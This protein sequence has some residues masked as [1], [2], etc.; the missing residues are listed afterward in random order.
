MLVSHK[1][2]FIFIANPKTATT[3]ISKFLRTHDESIVANRFENETKKIKFNEHAFPTV[4]KQKLDDEYNNYTKFVFIRHPYEKVVSAYFFLKNGKPLTKGSVF[5]YTDSLRNFLTALLI[6]FNVLSTKIIPFKL[7]SLIRPIKKN[8]S[9]LLDSSETFIVNYIGLTERL[10]EDLK[11]I[12]QALHVELNNFEGVQKINTSSHKSHEDYFQSGLHKK[13]FDRI[14][15]RE[16]ELYQI[17]KDR[18]SNFNFEGIKTTEMRLP[19]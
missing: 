7:W 3:A 15:A 6:Y 16:I 13:I 4:I 9:Y 14:Y 12:M 18:G 8:K 11:K 5:K 17:I 1:H 10:D 19:N 2:K